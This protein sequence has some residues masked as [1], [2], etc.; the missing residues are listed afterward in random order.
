[1][2]DELRILRVAFC[3]FWPGFNPESFFVPL[4][5]EISDGAVVVSDC[6]DAELVFTSVF[7]FNRRKT[8]SRVLTAKFRE[9]AFRIRGFSA[10]DAYLGFRLKKGQK[11]IWYTGENERPPLIDFD[12]SISFDQDDMSTKNVYFPLALMS[13]DWWGE[14]AH[15]ETPEYKR[16]GTSI[17]HSQAVLGRDTN[18]G[19]RGN[20]AC[21]F[22]GR[23]EP[24][25]LRAIRVL[26]ELTGKP[27]DV[28]GKQGHVT[29]KSKFEIA[30]DYRFMFCFENDAY[31]GYVTE[32]ALEAW[33]CGCIPIWYGLDQ[34]K[35]L[36]RN[37]LINFRDFEN[38]SQMIG[39]VRDLDA[40]HAEMSKVASRPILTKSSLGKMK[41]LR[42]AI[43]DLIV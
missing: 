26:E 12:L 33:A 39:Y 4:L 13:L 15:A 9:V 23:P 22:I 18:T 5:R 3:N 25:R 1:M 32:K 29:S 36:N 34:H 8:L 21:A 19:T 31:P 7:N 42:K 20:F 16:L 41:A 10:T 11:L 43:A 28:F 24:S 14:Q 35:I 2:E 17:S 37:A 6:E 27:V 30:S 40:N 38:L